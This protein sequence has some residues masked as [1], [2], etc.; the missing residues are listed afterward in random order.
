MVYE[1]INDFEA[2]S[3]SNSSYEL[4]AEDTV[5]VNNIVNDTVLIL[6]NENDYLYGKLYI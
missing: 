1:I 3:K 5:V 6:N 4:L 2:I